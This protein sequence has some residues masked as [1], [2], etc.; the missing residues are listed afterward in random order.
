MTSPIH[1]KP[2]CD[3]E[4]SIVVAMH[5]EQE[6][7]GSFFDRLLPVVR[8]LTPSYE[9]ICIND[10]SGDRTLSILRVIADADPH[11]RVIDFSRN[12]GKEAALSAGLAHARGSATF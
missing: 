8:R 6:V 5:N 4:L 10:G 2:H 7:I 3:V 1:Q 11:V 12:F 9:I